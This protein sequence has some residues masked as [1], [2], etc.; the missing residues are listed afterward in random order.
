MTSQSSVVTASTGVLPPTPR[1]GSVVSIVCMIELLCTGPAATPAAAQAQPQVNIE[2]KT[3]G[4]Q[5]W[6]SLVEN[7]VYWHKPTVIALPAEVDGVLRQ[8]AGDSPLLYDPTYSNTE[9]TVRKLSRQVKSRVAGI[10]VETD[11]V[12]FN[13]RNKGSKSLF[14]PLDTMSDYSVWYVP[15][16]ANQRWNVEVDADVKYD[17]Y[18]SSETLARRFADAVVSVRQPT[19]KPMQR[20][21][22]GMYVRDLNA[23]QA[24]D[25]GR[26]RIEGV[27]ITLVAIG[28]PADLAGIHALDVILEFNRKPMLNMDQL[29]RE[30][31]A[32]EAGASVPVVLLRRIVAPEGTKP[33]YT[34]EQK[35]LTMTVN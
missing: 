17:F 22:S 32:V 27:L 28:S 31:L 16:H 3:Q 21:L 10:K 12:S 24:A 29:I 2:V 5:I 14:V 9:F 23:D 26:S 7:Q 15:K 6:P 18:F 33:S 30:L 19:A 4:K 34:W 1:V 25:A 35:S 13:G 8:A 11:W 20:K